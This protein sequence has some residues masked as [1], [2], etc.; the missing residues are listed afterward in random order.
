MYLN[1]IAAMHV[2]LVCLRAYSYPL[3]ATTKDELNCI[4]QGIKIRKPYAEIKDLG[5]VENEAELDRLL[6]RIDCERLDLIRSAL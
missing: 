1:L 3:V 5:R 6:D 4:C 2:A